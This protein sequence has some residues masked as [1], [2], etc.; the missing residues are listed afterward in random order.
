MNYRQILRKLFLYAGAEKEEYHALSADIRKENQ[1]LLSVFS[2][3]G[4]II[5]F[6]LFI[7]SMLSNGFANMNS[8]TYLLIFL[9]T[10]LAVALTLGT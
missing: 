7:A 2:L 8:S 6:L 1:V 3:L 10:A 5:F 9:F 4:G